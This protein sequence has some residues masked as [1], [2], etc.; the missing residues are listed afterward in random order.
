MSEKKHALVI[1]DSPEL[2]ASGA[3]LPKL[4]A[5]AV[6]Q[7]K[8]IRRTESEASQRAIL[9]GLTLYRIKASMKGTFTDWLK[10]DFDVLGYRQARYYMAA[11]LA[12]I[13]KTKATLPEF[14]AL[15]GDQ[16]E[17]QL[18][19]VP[20]GKGRA[21]MAKIEKFV[22]DRSLGE[23]FEDLGI[24]EA[25]KK[26]RGAGGGDDTEETETAETS[27]PKSPQDLCAEIE[28]QLALARKAAADPAVWM[29]LSKK[30]HDGLKEAFEAAA[31]RIATI[32]AKT[33]GKKK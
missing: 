1:V 17:L 31:E 18:A 6:H 24:K 5:A 4:Q 16:A 25:K 11:S 12:F 15:P 14:L 27:A 20:E 3:L 21:L 29:Q 19:A 23:M 30:Q 26:K 9:L 7:V 28:E 22:G 33:H 32:H 8:L 10:K 13:E 2:S